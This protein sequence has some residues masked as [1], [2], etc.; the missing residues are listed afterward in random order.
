MRPSASVVSAVG[1]D[2]ARPYRIAHARPSVPQF[3][4]RIGVQ[5]A[6]RGLLPSSPLIK[7]IADSREQHVELEVALDDSDVPADKNLGSVPYVIRGRKNWNFCWT[8]IGAEY[9]GVIRPMVVTCR[10]HN[11]DPYDYLIDVL[12]RITGGYQRSPDVENVQFC[13]ICFLK[14]IKKR[15][16]GIHW[17]RFLNNEALNLPSCPPRAMFPNATFVRVRQ[18]KYIRFPSRYRLHISARASVTQ[19]IAMGGATWR[20]TPEERDLTELTI[21]LFE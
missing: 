7:A 11:I 10:L 17:H 5:F 14:G 6:H 12:R 9:V 20:T 19:A 2:P 8:E 1:R 13:T 21:D 15:N 18:I 3:L 16:S 4:A